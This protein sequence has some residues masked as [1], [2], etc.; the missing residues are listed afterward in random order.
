LGLSLSGASSGSLQEA[1]KELQK[2]QKERQKIIEQQ[3]VQEAQK[4]LEAERDTR[5]QELGQEQITAMDGLTN[6]IEYL[7]QTIQQ[8]TNPSTG[9]PT[10][11]ALFGLQ[12]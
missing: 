12:Q 10:D 9:Q 5:I 7:T 3:M 2:I 11:P 6:A 8:R 4:Q 1:Q